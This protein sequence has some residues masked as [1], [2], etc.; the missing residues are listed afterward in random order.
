MY[1]VGHAQC[2]LLAYHRSDRRLTIGPKQE[3]ENGNGNKERVPAGR[4]HIT[5]TAGKVGRA[6]HAEGTAEVGCRVIPSRSWTGKQGG[7]C[8][9][10]EKKRQPRAYRDKYRY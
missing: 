10:N 4:K 2:C 1:L 5:E 9:G 8:Y 3:D 7:F 6:G